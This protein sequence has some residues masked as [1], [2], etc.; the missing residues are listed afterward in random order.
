MKLYLLLQFLTYEFHLLNLIFFSL[1][2]ASLICLK[3]EVSMGMN[4][5]ITIKFQINLQTL[6]F[7][8]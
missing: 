3:C 6:A 2:K 8:F 5:Y 4:E 7:K 1:V